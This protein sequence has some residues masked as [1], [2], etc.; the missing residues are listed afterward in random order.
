MILF[1]AIGII[2]D[3]ILTVKTKTRQKDTFFSVLEALKTDDVRQNYLVQLAADTERLFDSVVVVTD[4]RISERL[5][6]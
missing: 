6:T 4:R 2:I 1:M 3:T 5:L